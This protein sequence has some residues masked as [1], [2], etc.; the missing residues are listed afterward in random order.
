MKG[1]VVGDEVRGVAGVQV[2]EGVI[3][4]NEDFSFSQ[5]GSTGGF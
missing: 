4:C 3:G 2:M 1:P 5:I